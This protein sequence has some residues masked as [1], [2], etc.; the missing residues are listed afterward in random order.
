MRFL[1]RIIVGVIAAWLTGAIVTERGFG[2]VGDLILVPSV[3]PGDLDVGD[4]LLPR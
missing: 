1:I 4:Q 3:H 2:L